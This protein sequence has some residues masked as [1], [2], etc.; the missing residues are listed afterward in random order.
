VNVFYL[1]I[2]RTA[3]EAI[4]NGCLLQLIWNAGARYWHETVLFSGFTLEN[5]NECR[6]SHWGCT[7]AKSACV[8]GQC[9]LVCR[10]TNLMWRYWFALWVFLLS[11]SS[12]VQT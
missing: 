1:S 7:T 10:G 9:F 12:Q 3:F 4:Q 6:S 5:T 11:T 8:A 2:Q